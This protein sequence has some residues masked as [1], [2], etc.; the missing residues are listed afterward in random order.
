M[1]LPEGQKVLQDER[2]QNYTPPP[3]PRLCRGI[4]SENGMD[5]K[6]RSGPMLYSYSQKA[7]F[8]DKHIPRQ[9]GLFP[10][11]NIHIQV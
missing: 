5:A 11:D 7:V 2:C 8:S 1:E 9:P 3:T 6:N 10:Q 4:K